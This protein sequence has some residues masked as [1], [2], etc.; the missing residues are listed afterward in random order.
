MYFFNIPFSKVTIIS[1]NNSLISSNTSYI[2][3][4]PLL[5][6]MYLVLPFL[7]PPF[8]PAPSS[9]N[10]HPNKVHIRDLEIL[11]FK[12][13]LLYKNTP[14][15]PPT[16]RIELLKKPGH[17]CRRTSA[18]PP[19]WFGLITSSWWYHL[20]SSTQGISSKVAVRSRVLIR[21]KFS[22]FRQEFFIF[23]CIE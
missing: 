21:F 2:E 4:L 3:I 15:P 1:N 7:L 11:C 22:S 12:S 16:P 13:L 8:S 6:S 23:C 17:L 19:L 9:A 5:S 10:Q 20:M 18:H 14:H